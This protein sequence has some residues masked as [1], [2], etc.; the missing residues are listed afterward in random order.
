MSTK[1]KIFFLSPLL[2]N[3]K[4]SITDEEALDHNM[5]NYLTNYSQPQFYDGFQK[6]GFDFIENF[7]EF[8]DKEKSK[9]LIKDIY[10]KVNSKVQS[11]Y[12]DYY[13]NKSIFLVER[14]DIRDAFNS[15]YREIQIYQLLK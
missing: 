14:E 6:L 2:A 10:I 4:F 11:S 1:Y 15:L 5:E 3:P 7:I 13:Q 9:Y 12:Y 8:C